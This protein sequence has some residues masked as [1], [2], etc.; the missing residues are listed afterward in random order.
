MRKAPP[1]TRPSGDDGMGGA[2]SR[3]QG[4]PGNGI[5]VD[6]P[7]A[8][9]A[10]TLLYQL[11]YGGHDSPDRSGHDSPNRSEASNGKKASH[12]SSTLDLC[13]SSSSS[14]K[15]M[16]YKPD[17]LVFSDDEDYLLDIDYDSEEEQL[18][19]SFPKNKKQMN[20]IPGGPQP[21]D[22][23]MYPESEQKAVLDAY[24]AKRKSFTD[25][26]RHQLV[27]K[28]N[29]EAKLSATVS[30]DQIEQ[31]CPMSVIEAHRLVD[32]DSFKNKNVL[33]LRIS[34]EANLRGNTTRANRSDVMNLTIIGINFYVNAVSPLIN[35]GTQH[36][37]RSARAWMKRV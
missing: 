34:E 20:I 37:R 17:G 8:A 5:V 12:C 6:T 10:S 36:N 14:D 32:G 33:K 7:M 16:D 18:R 15:D 22:L 2:L 19:S 30:A 4:L 9:A 13:A 26:N 25:R 1:N 28:K 3:E 24:T 27:K 21:P 35:L 11:Q 31:L 29:L 23:S